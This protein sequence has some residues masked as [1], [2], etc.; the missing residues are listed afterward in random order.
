M[1]EGEAPARTPQ[2]DQQ[3]EDSSPSNIIWLRRDHAAAHLDSLDR[4]SAR[5][6][7]ELVRR[8]KLN[9][10]LDIGVSSAA[11]T[12][13]AALCVPGAALAATMRSTLARDV[14]A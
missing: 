11:R 6:L 13:A 5:M 3:E 7:A 12:L 14:P 2:P 1:S 10:T 8:C 4:H 9:G